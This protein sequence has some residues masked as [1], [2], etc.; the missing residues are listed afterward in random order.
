MQVVELRP[1]EVLIS[2]KL[3]YLICLFIVESDIKNRMPM[4]QQGQLETAD[5]S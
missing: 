4:A 2:I 3:K 1:V 5:Y